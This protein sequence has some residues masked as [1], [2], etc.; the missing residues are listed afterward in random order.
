MRRYALA[1]LY[2]TIPIDAQNKRVIPKTL[3]ISTRTSK[4]LRFGIWFGSQVFFFLKQNFSLQHR[5]E[6]LLLIEYST[7]LNNNT[8]KLFYFAYIMPQFWIEL[9][10]RVCVCVC[11]SLLRWHRWCQGDNYIL[12]TYLLQH[13]MRFTTFKPHSYTYIHT[14]TLTH[15]HT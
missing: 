3:M 8:F 13:T 12:A 15:T 9:I 2:C 1:Y 5:P 11:V 10:L 7:K 4:L 6:L 14:Y